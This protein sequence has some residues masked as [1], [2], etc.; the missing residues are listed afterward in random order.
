MARTHWAFRTECYSESFNTNSSTEA[1]VNL[2]RTSEGAWLGNGFR[3]SQFSGGKSVSDQWTSLV[4]SSPSAG[5]STT[6]TTSDQGEQQQY[7]YATQETLPP[8]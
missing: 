3:A 5:T 2:R 8:H 1:V 6:T 7:K 4:S